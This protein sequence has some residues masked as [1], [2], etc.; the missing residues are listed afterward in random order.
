MAR[1]LTDLRHLVQLRQ[2]PGLLIQHQSVDL[3]P[4]VVA[5]DLRCLI[6][7]IKRVERERTSDHRLGIHRCQMVGIEQPALYP[8]VKA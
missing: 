2:R 1:H 6:L 3:Q 8:I 5:I 7:G 4:V